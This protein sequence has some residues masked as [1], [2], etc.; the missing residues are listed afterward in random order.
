MLQVYDIKVEPNH[1]SL[2]LAFPYDNIDSIVVAWEEL[3]ADFEQRRPLN[4][5]Q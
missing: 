2:Y 1:L 3:K 4:L 5:E